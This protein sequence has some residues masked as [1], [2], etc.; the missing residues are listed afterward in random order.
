MDF[1]RKARWVLD[2]HKCEAPTISSY[3]GVVSRESIR[4][5]LTYA[6]RNDV[7]VFAADI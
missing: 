4:I 1:T 7:D 2:G 6:A 5:V 3:A